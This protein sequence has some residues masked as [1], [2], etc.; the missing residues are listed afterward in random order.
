[1]ESICLSYLLE[2][3]SICWAIVNDQSSKHTESTP[4]IIQGSE[5]S[6]NSARSIQWN[7][8]LETKI[9][10]HDCFQ[11]VGRMLNREHPYFI[12]LEGFT[13]FL[14]MHLEDKSL[15]WRETSAY[16]LKD[17]P[18]FEKHALKFEIHAKCGKS[19]CATLTLPHGHCRTPMFMPF[20]LFHW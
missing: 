11:P 1:M 16:P 18:S 9:P 19:R 2:S 5:I 13:L 6:A 8:L 14:L 4:G 15:P 10:A 3:C 7:D 17:R 12:F 20:E